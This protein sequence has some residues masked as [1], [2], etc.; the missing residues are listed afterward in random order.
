MPFQI[1]PLDVEQFTHLFSLTAA[2]LDAASIVER[3]ALEPHSCPCRVSL[4]D[5]EVGEKLLLV[6]FEHLPVDSPY[7]SNHA[8]YVRRDAQTAQ[9]SCSAPV[10]CFF[11]FR[12]KA[13]LPRTLTRRK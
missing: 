3:T 8:I 6:N 10:N 9:P 12:H 13:P 11:H 5:A 1:R 2:Q 4:V 7:R